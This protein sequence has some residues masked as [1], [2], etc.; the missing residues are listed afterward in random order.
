MLRALFGQHHFLITA[1]TLLVAV[2]TLTLALPVEAN[3]PVETVFLMG[4]QFQVDYLSVGE[5]PVWIEAKG[6][7]IRTIR[8][9]VTN[10]GCTAVSLDPF[11]PTTGNGKGRGGGGGK[12]GGGGPKAPK[13]A[14]MSHF[15]VGVKFSD[16]SH[17][18]E[19][20]DGPPLDVAP[21]DASGTAVDSFKVTMDHPECVVGVYDCLEG[22]F[23]PTYG[24]SGS[25]K[26]DGL[27]FSKSQSDPS[28]PVTNT[29]IFEFSYQF[30][31]EQDVQ[32]YDDGPMQVLVKPGNQFDIGDLWGPVTTP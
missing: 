21:M 6:F 3:T 11:L 28:L 13:C 2:F 18:V 25:T 24:F 22:L 5:E 30:T 29:F 9:A 27:K 1:L 4:G 23:T 8:Y 15:S 32:L 17:L 12:D 19:L 26:F 10:H 16:E 14:G 20:L 31:D 7:Y